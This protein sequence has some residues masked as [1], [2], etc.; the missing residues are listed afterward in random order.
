MITQRTALAIGKF[1]QGAFTIMGMQTSFPARENLYEFFLKRN[2]SHEF[3]DWVRSFVRTPSDLRDLFINLSRDPKFQD[4]LKRAAEDIL[5]AQPTELPGQG[6]YRDEPSRESLIARAWSSMAT[7][8]ATATSWS[9]KASSSKSP[10]GRPSGWV[11]HLLELR[12]LEAGDELHGRN[13]EAE[14]VP[15]SDLGFVEHP[16]KCIPAVTDVVSASHS[17]VGE[18]PVAQRMTFGPSAVMIHP[19]SS[20]DLPSERLRRSSSPSSAR[21]RSSTDTTWPRSGR[22]REIASLANMAWPDHPKAM[23]RASSYTLPA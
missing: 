14:C 7:R 21:C 16:S 8:S 23:L 5:N 4:S 15:G 18:Y 3:C 6:Y 10:R 13:I 2:Y 1:Y 12:L 9:R 22:K 11:E 19:V 17:L 20:S